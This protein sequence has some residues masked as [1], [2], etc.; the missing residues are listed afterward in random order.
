[1]TKFTLKNAKWT[2]FFW[3][4]SKTYLL[5]I[6]IIMDLKLCNLS[7]RLH[8]GQQETQP[9]RYKH[10]HSRDCYE[11]LVAQKPCNKQQ[12]TEWGQRTWIYT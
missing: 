9:S 2:S 3:H 6:T 4:R 5:P 8:K 12:I 1:M 10:D 7:S 11:R